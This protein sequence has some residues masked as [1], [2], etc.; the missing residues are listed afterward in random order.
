MKEPEYITVPP[1]VLVFSR[2]E[3]MSVRSWDPF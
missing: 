2:V 1:P 3:V